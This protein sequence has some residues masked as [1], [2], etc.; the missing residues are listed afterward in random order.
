MRISDAIPVGLKW[1]LPRFCR[2]VSFARNIKA[3]L[4]PAGSIFVCAALVT[5]TPINSMAIPISFRA[6]AGS[7]E[8]IK[9]KLCW[10]NRAANSPRVEILF[11]F[12]AVNRSGGPTWRTTSAWGIIVSLRATPFFRLFLNCVEVEV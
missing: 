5:A 10:I 6:K 12:T 4:F 1:G 11:K 8:R 3:V 9:G 7:E 2:I